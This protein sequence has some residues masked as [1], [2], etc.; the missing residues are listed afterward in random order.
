MPQGYNPINPDFT[1]P[2][3]NVKN[4]VN[5]NNSNNQ[6]THNSTNTSTGYNSSGNFNNGILNNNVNNNGGPSANMYNAYGAQNLL[7]NPYNN[8]SNNER[9]VTLGKIEGTLSNIQQN[10]SGGTHMD[11]GISSVRDAKDMV[12]AFGGNKVIENFVNA[13]NRIPY[14]SNVVDYYNA[15]NVNKNF[16]QS[17]A[18][19]I[20]NALPT[21]SARSEYLVYKLKCTENG[22]KN[23]MSESDFYAKAAS[24]KA[25]TVTDK[26]GKVVKEFKHDNIDIRSSARKELTD[27]RKNEKINTENERVDNLGKG[28]VSGKDFLEMRNKNYQVLNSKYKLDGFKGTKE[29]MKLLTAK[30]RSTNVKNPFNKLS[31]GDVA[32]ISAFVETNGAN[33]GAFKSGYLTKSSSRGGRILSNKF[34]DEKMSSG[35]NTVRGGVVAVRT[36]AKASNA[37]YLKSSGHRI[38]KQLRKLEYDF[39]GGNINASE[40]NDLKNLLTNKKDIVDTKKDLSKTSKRGKAGREARKNKKENLKDLKKGK[41]DLLK[42]R[43]DKVKNRGRRSKYEERNPFKRWKNRSAVKPPLKQRLA[44]FGKNFVHGIKNKLVSIPKNIGKMFKLGAKAI[45]LLIKAAAIMF[46]ILAFITAV[47]CIVV[48][49]LDFFSFDSDDDLDENA[50]QTLNKK[51][52]AYESGDLLEKYKNEVKDGAPTKEGKYSESEGWDLKVADDVDINNILDENGKATNFCNCLQIF[53]LYTYY[54]SNHIDFFSDDMDSFF[55]TDIKPAIDATH[56][57]DNV[58]YNVTYCDKNEDGS[59][60]GCNNIRY[61]NDEKPLIFNTENY[62]NPDMVTTKADGSTLIGGMDYDKWDADKS[63]FIAKC[64]DY[65]ETVSS[66]VYYAS[67]THKWTEK[68]PYYDSST[69]VDVDTSDGK[70]GVIIKGKAEDFTDTDKQ[71][72]ISTSGELPS[73]V[74]ITSLDASERQKSYTLYT[75]DEIEAL[76]YTLVGDSSWATAD[77]DYYTYYIPMKK[78]VTSET[79]T[80]DGSVP[81]AI[82]IEK[83]TR[84]QLKAI[85]FKY[86]L[87]DEERTDNI[88]EGFYYKT[89][90]CKGHCAGHISISMDLHAVTNIR[91]TKNADGTTTDGLNTM[92]YEGSKGWFDGKHKMHLDEDELSDVEEMIG[93]YDTRYIDGVKNWKEFD[94]YFMGVEGWIDDADIE[95]IVSGISSSTVFPTPVIG[96]DTITSMGTTEDKKVLISNALNLCGHFTYGHGGRGNLEAMDGTT[97][98]S[99]FVS[100]AIYFALKE[101]GVP[102]DDPRMA[103]IKEVPTTVGLLK[104]CPNGYGYTKNL[105]GGIA[106]LPSGT[107]LVKQDL[108]ADAASNGT[109]GLSNHTVIY[110]GPMDL[111]GDGAMDDGG[112]PYIIDCT[113]SGGYSGA[114]PHTRSWDYINNYGCYAYWL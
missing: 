10:T 86:E 19:D 44:S 38:D 42:D 62:Y 89:I 78:S 46:I 60:D 43:K 26:N 108:A 56:S 66:E 114:R 81:G 35:M 93:T 54:K 22:I 17:L 39:K 64:D 112:N 113:T 28:H 70:S 13:S 37:V 109:T 84:Y 24:G 18:K 77:S 91:D 68:V 2:Y 96:S 52:T 27:I 40:Y 11:N 8:V 69:L 102:D 100:K 36:A 82:K 85:Q 74:D 21:N 105:S 23:P 107:V 97:D 104:S 51:A 50:W 83:S 95:A 15:N 71:L 92:L 7:L 49:I 20:G 98:C 73:E 99:G 75:Q 31:E 25:I 88:K 76:G 57:Y 106:S 79:K 47:M 48:I 111:D 61:H 58:D 59:L 55:D 12:M 1:N 33:I 103:A 101:K 67:V 4:P 87:V 34:V 14:K 63:A 5:P 9:A 32:E 72:S 94:V 53:S 30:D 45:L 110:L 16:H 3:E 29:Q 80:V 65:E 90:K 6:N 41:K